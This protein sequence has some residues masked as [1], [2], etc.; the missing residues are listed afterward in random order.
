MTYPHQ[1]LLTLTYPVTYRHPLS[2]SFPSFNLITCSLSS[3]L[4]C[5]SLL[6]SLSLSDHGEP[7]GSV[8]QRG[9]ATPSAGGHHPTTNTSE[10]DGDWASD[11]SGSQDGSSDWA[12]EGA[13]TNPFSIQRTSP[14]WT[15]PGGWDCEFDCQLTCPHVFFISGTLFMSSL[16]KKIS[17]NS[18]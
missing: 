15:G 17:I 3:A 5:S 7:N 13:K 1:I 6:S 16:K 9:G 12:A 14:S 11:S 18:N 10:G 4:L 2:S 8:V